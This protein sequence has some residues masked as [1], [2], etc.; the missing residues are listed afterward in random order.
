MSRTSKDADIKEVMPLAGGLAPRHFARRIVYMLIVSL[1]AVSL[2]WIVACW[3]MSFSNDHEWLSSFVEIAFALNLALTF[4]KV[5]DLML[6]VKQQILESR[7]TTISHSKLKG[8]LDKSIKEVLI[9][10]SSSMLKVYEHRC[11]SELQFIVKLGYVFAFLSVT[12]L[13]TDC[14][15]AFIKFV[16]MLIMP[17]IVFKSC[18]MVESLFSMF[19]FVD[20]VKSSAEKL[21]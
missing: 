4:P 8:T 5:Q 11:K 2:W 16:P 14:N 10:L 17:F 18:L 20:M 1:L 3:L 13:L 21:K 19:E 7:F 6:T 9:L 15:E 12:I